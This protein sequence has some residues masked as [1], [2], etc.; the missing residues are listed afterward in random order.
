MWDA[1]KARLGGGEFI[2]LNTCII[3][4]GH[5]I[6]D[7]SS[8]PKE[9]KEKNGLKTKQKKKKGQSGNQ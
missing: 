8:H 6:S 4:D 3:K 2:V 5:G 7:L 9:L 1:S